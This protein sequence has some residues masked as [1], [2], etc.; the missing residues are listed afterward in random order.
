M[1]TQH[2]GDMTCGYLDCAQWAD[3]P[4]GSNA[5]FTKSAIDA[6][7]HD[8]TEFLLACGPLADQAI[9]AYGASRFGH[10]FWLTRCG[11]GAGYWDR[12]E[13]QIEPCTT[14]IIAID[15]NGKH[16][17]AMLRGNE[18]GDVLSNIAY[19]NSP[20]ISKFAYASLDAYRGWLYFYG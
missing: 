9:D 2:L 16:Y 13:L 19:G 11:H 4:E 1:N 17:G 3:K 6:A 18:L 7:R 5:R 10:D 8:C 20:N 14:D 15:R 12:D